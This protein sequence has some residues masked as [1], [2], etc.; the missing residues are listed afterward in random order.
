ME[1]YEE[2]ENLINILQSSNKD[3]DTEITLNKLEKILEEYRIKRQ[4]GSYSNN[5]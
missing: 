5:R 1:F 3:V 4:Y 2:V